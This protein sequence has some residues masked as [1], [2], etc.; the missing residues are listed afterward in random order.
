MYYKLISF[1]YAEL[2]KFHRPRLMNSPASETSSSDDPRP[3]H[4]AQGA[5]LRYFASRHCAACLRVLESKGPVDGS[6]GLC[7]ECL[8]DPRGTV[9]GLSA[10]VRRWDASRRNLRRICGLCAGFGEH[11]PS[12]HCVSLDC[13]VFYRSAEAHKEASQIDHVQGIL[14]KLSF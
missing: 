4:R 7:P 2:P 6:A 12:A 13:P 9:L 5:I 8:S 10:R 14:D 11:E 3:R 1:R